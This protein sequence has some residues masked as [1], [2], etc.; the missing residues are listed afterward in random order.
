MKN[1]DNQNQIVI[2]VDRNIRSMHYIQC[3]W[4]R[5]VRFN[6]SPSLSDWMDDLRETAMEVDN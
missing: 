6:R 2:D 5:G 3:E 4:L 1:L